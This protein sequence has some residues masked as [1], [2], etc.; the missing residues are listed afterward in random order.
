VGLNLVVARCRTCGVA[1]PEHARFCPGCGASVASGPT[2]DERKLATV[3]FAD[4]VGSTALGDA[5]DPERIR[6]L[7]E[8]LFGAVADEIERVGGTVD[9]FIGDAVMASFGAP[10]AMEDH[11]ARALQAALA[12]QERVRDL[13][14]DGVHLRIGVNTGEVVVGFARSGGSFATGDTVNVAARLEQAAAPD[15]V[16]V[17]E[18]TVALAGDDFEFSERKTIEAKGKPEGVDCRC[19]LGARAGSR[20]GRRSTG[21]AE[22]LVGRDPELRALGRLYLDAVSSG[23]P[24]VVTLT[25]DAGVGKTR[26][27]TEV[28]TWF[29][30]HCGARLLQGRCLAYGRG[31]TYWPFAEIL[32][33][34]FDIS[35][36]D[37]TSVVMGRLAGRDI[38]GLTFGLDVAGDLHPF[39]AQERLHEAWVEVINEL[40]DS[41]PV[42]LLVEDIHWAEDSLL[43]LLA[44]IAADARGHV[45]VLLTARPEFLDLHPAW[46]APLPRTTKMS[47]EPL[48]QDA[49]RELLRELLRGPSP[50]QLIELVVGRAEGNPFYVEEIVRMLID[51]DALTPTDDG[52]TVSEL[53]R[54]EVPDSVQAVLASRI[55]L[56]DAS[57][58]ATLQ[59]ASVI[60]RAF[61]ATPVRLL[62]GQT[63]DL[64]TLE[65]R[66]FIR[67]VADSSLPGEREFAFRHALTRQVAYEG[68]PRA[69][70]ARLHAAFA[71][72]LETTGD[73]RDDR[74]PLCSDTTTPKPAIPSMQTSPTATTPQNSTACERRRDF[75]SSERPTSRSDDTRSVTR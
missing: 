46:A 66:E 13:F 55:D 30:T 32:R 28:R 7:L 5:E 47:L 11:A 57:Q 62:V 38:L 37:D 39:A 29:A 44:R 56:L 58:K 2:I 34:L 41:A 9:K 40:A 21:R 60:G 72:W 54:M 49:T 25:G 48:S 69:R 67:G 31:V 22:A 65:D 50:E 42:F 75:G 14:G 73:D 35:E 3:L 1:L 10:S 71:D 52:W 43:D 8:R 63:P 4:L 17:G 53:A 15:Q 64:R 23:Q 45:L 70:R 33:D 59:A 27:S 36:A 74:A 68:L 6:L 61:W 26:L 12:I 20:L 19:L 24:A 18:R 51:R 16:L